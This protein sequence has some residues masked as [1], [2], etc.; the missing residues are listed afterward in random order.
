MVEF[1]FNATLTAKVM[2]IGYAFVFPGFLTPVLTQLFSPK[3]STT[4][5]TCFCRGE[6]RKYAG[7]NSRLNRGS[8]SQPP[9]HES[10]T[11]TTEPPGRG[12]KDI[13]T[14]DNF[15]Y[16]TILNKQALKSMKVKYPLIDLMHL[17]RMK[18]LWGKGKKIAIFP[19]PAMFSNA[20]LLGAVNPFLHIYSFYH[21]EKKKAFRKT[22]W[23]KMKLLKM[24]NFTF[25]HNV[26]FAICVLKSFDSHI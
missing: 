25:F 24:S 21:I 14:G 11:L 9:D 3:P 19:F 22:M 2:A 6:R 4:S 10:D 26:F 15:L 1:G 12:P 8:N 18:S 20:F 23:K 17:R 7:I 5:F 16:G 13:L